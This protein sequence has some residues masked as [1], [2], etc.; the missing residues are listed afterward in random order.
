MGC[1]RLRTGATTTVSGRPAGPPPPGGGRGGWSRGP[2]P[3]GAPVGL[4]RFAGGGEPPQHRDPPPDRVGLRGEPLVRQGFPAGEAGH[5]AR[6]KERAQGRGQVFGLAGGGGDREHEAV[7]SVSLT[8]QR[9]GEHRPEG[10]RRDEIFSGGGGGVSPDL[11]NSVGFRT[12][13]YF[14]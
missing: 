10:R 6:G 14:V 2:P 3:R 4:A 12:R 5:A 7:R 9:G 1:S 13:D 11:W 8:G